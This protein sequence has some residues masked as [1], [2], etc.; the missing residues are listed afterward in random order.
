MTVNPGTRLTK[1]PSYP[2]ILEDY[3]KTFE[4]LASLKPDIFF[5]GHASFFG[6]EKKRTKI[7]EKN[8]AA[9]FVDPQGFTELVA[10]K[11]AEFDKYVAGEK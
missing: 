1:D 3:R 11:R 4:T 5:S 8:P 7:N 9:A 6:L 2:S 10:Q